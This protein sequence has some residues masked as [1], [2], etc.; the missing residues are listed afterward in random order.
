MERITSCKVTTV[1]AVI[2]FVVYVLSKETNIDAILCSKG[3]NYIGNQYWRFFSAGFVQNNLIHVL[4]N[5]YLIIWLGTRYESIVG[6]S[7][8]FIIGFIGS[9]IAYFVFGCI[10][11]NAICSIGGSGYWYT[12]VGYI[13]I[14]QIKVP[15]FSVIGQK[16]MLLYALVF[17]PVIP[18]I[19]GMNMS[20][21]VFHSLAFATG[22]VLGFIQI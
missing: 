4:G 6:S 20:T 8:F 18:I 5:I 7:Q 12:L 2:W 10:Y 15:G 13:L 3:M 19:P 9:A 11:K 14:Q 21:A 22:V 17:L 1:L 16:W